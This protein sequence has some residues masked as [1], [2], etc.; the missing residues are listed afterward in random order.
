MNRLL[1]VLAVAFSLMLATPASALTHKQQ[2]QS[3]IRYETL[4]AGYHL[5]DVTAMYILAE[6][7]STTGCNPRAYARGRQCVGLY[8][9]DSGKGSYAQRVNDRW[10]TRRA[11]A[12]IR[13]RYGN[14][15]RALAHSYNTGWY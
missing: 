14:P 13:G 3:I 2:V 8:Q 6:R 7:E 12:Y 11:L 9:L 4:R 10:N 1:F 15:Q 5:H